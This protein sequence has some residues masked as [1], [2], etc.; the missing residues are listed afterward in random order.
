ML[1]I[2]NKQLNQANH[3]LFSSNSNNNNLKYKCN[4]TN[5][6][7]L[8][9]NNYNILINDFQNSQFPSKFL[10]LIMMQNPK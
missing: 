5:R 10:K 1:T 3:S 8:Q 2:N 6:K 7:D 4:S 9:H